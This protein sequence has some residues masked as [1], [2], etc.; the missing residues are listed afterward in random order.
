MDLIN[1][2]FLTGVGLAFMTKEKIEEMSRELME[3]GRLS[4]KEGRQLLEDLLK[5]SEK[6]KK[7]IEAQIEKIVKESLKKMNIATTDDLKAL[8]KKIRTL[9][10]KLEQSEES[11][12]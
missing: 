7:D 3:K 4:E 6:A 8:E 11:G 12:Q 1:K 5:K 10:K 2:M 9:E